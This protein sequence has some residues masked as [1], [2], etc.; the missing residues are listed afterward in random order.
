MMNTTTPTHLARQLMTGQACIQTRKNPMLQCN[1][2]CVV[3]H[4]RPSVVL[5]A[6]S[7]TLLFNKIHEFL[8]SRLGHEPYNRIWDPEVF[9]YKNRSIKTKCGLPPSLLC[10]GRDEPTC[11]FFV[12]AHRYAITSTTRY[13]TATTSTNIVI[14]CQHSQSHNYKS[15]RERMLAMLLPLRC[16]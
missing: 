1:R 16:C 9:R 2:T 3:D 15:Y 5:L 14:Q 7:R 13:A 12:F 8:C 11:I 4:S 10:L 6:A